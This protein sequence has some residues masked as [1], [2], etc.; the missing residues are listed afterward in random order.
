MEKIQIYMKKNT[1]VRVRNVKEYLKKVNIY[2]YIYIYKP[3][4]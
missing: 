2:I 3:I 1:N 4:K